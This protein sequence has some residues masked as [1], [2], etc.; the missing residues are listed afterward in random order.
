MSLSSGFT[1]LLVMTRWLPSLILLWSLSEQ[2]PVQQQP[3]EIPIDFSLCLSAL[4]VPELLLV[5]VQ[6][7]LALTDDF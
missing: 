4:K 6:S 2:G 1:V 7:K 5:L 3:Q